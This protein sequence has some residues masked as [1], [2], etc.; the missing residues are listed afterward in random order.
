[1]RNQNKHLSPAVLHAA[2]ATVH[3][4]GTPCPPAN[5]CN[6]LAAASPAH[7]AAAGTGSGTM[8][9]KVDEVWQKLKAGQAPRSV[10][11][12]RAPT[13]SGFG[14]IPGVSSTVRTYDKSRGPPQPAA[15]PSF[16][17]QLS[18]GPRSEEKQAQAGPD[19]QALLV[20]AGQRGTPPPL[21][22]PLPPPLPCFGEFDQLR[23]FQGAKDA[24]FCRGADSLQPCTGQNRNCLPTAANASTT[25]YCHPPPSPT[26]RP[27]CKGTLMA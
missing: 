17:A 16:I 10:S 25:C 15:R 13:L 19:H 26:C 21:L 1:M 5:G 14:G 20:G 7:S 18:E 8:S 22:P 11:S 2:W 27:P 4:V 3:P 9:D 6:C 12:R 23:A 24:F